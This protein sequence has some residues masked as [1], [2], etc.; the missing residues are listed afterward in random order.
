MYI[1][2]DCDYYFIEGS[3]CPKCGSENISI[4]KEKPKME[5]DLEDDLL[6]ELVFSEA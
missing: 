5:L 1:C 2:D 3:H 6:K 4:A